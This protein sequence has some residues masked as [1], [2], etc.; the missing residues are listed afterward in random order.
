ME[1]GGGLASRRAVTSRVQRSTALTSGANATGSCVAHS[2]TL[3]SFHKS[4]VPVAEASPRC[5]A[6][7]KAAALSHASRAARSLAVVA[8]QRSRSA[9]T[10]GSD[11]GCSAV[12]AGVDTCA[13]DV[14]CSQIPAFP[15]SHRMSGGGYVRRVAGGRVAVV[16]GVYTFN[17]PSPELCRVADD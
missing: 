17:E 2:I 6:S 3:D 10:H 13:V 16:G 5:C 1:I 14:A 9:P 15:L 12:G 7:T 8:V 4:C 11:D